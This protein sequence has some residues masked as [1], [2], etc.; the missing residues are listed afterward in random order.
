MNERSDGGRP[1]PVVAPRARVKGVRGFRA[2]G[3]APLTAVTLR[4][5][6]GRPLRPVPPR[7]CACATPP[8]DRSGRSSRGW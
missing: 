6:P 4:E 3:H 2:S 7:G 8:P 1:R 5:E